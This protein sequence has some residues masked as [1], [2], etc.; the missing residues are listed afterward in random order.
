MY[1]QFRF[2]LYDLHCIVLVG[3]AVAFWLSALLAVQDV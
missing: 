1:L 2:C 3:T